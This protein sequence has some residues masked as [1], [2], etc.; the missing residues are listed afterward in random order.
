MNILILKT[1]I[2]NPEAI[3]RVSELLDQQPRVLTWSIDWE[4]I[5]HVL[6]IEGAEDLAEIEVID[7]M[8]SL[9]FECQDLPD[10]IPAGSS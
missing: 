9:G 10:E 6:R 8:K 2:C 5:D 1:N 3:D 7:W 4:D